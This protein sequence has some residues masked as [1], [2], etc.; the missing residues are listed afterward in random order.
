MLTLLKSERAEVYGIPNASDKKFDSLD[1]IDWEF[2][3]NNFSL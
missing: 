3:A 2:E 1:F